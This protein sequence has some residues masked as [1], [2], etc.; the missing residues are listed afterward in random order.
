MADSTLNLAEKTQAP[1]AAVAAVEKAEDF[2]KNFN[3]PLV[4]VGAS[5]MPILFNDDH[6]SL[7]T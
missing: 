6:H 4:K 5:H 3:Y 2:R 7:Q 1:A